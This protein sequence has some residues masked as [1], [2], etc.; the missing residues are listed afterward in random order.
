[1]SRGELFLI[2]A[3][4]GAG[5]T[6]LIERL[7]A[8]EAGLAGTIERVVSHT[9]RAPRAGEV[10]G[11]DR[12]FVDDARF[13]AMVENGEFLE[14]SVVHGHRYGTSRAEVEPRLASGL[15]LIHDLDVQGA[16]HFRSV[17]PSAHTVFVLPPSFRDLEA[18]LTGRGLDSAP[19]IARRLAVSLAECERYE[20]Y[21][22]VIVN[23]DATRATL[24]L[25][26]II[27]EKRLRRDRMSAVAEGVLADFRRAVRAL[28]EG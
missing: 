25:F 8:P 4:S 11:R 20:K 14:W 10:D 27:V 16:E 15:D 28:A 6:T 1:M 18:R 21:D 26:A 9:T 3:P 12:H 13:T 5:K 17:L 23:A 2:S 24:A 22:Y 19:T 7:L